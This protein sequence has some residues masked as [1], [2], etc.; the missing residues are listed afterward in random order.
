MMS[1]EL[2]PQWTPEH[3]Q[4]FMKRSDR[5][6]HDAIAEEHNAALA[7]ERD[8]ANVRETELICERD[9]FKGQLDAER[10]KVTNLSALLDACEKQLAEERVNA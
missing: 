5:K 9:Y 1:A 10:A 6:F 2:Q 8:N 7:A 4:S 3:V